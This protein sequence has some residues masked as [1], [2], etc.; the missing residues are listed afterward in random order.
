M[1]GSSI[2]KQWV[3]KNF[4]AHSALFAAVLQPV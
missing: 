4:E 2:A 1:K 3:S